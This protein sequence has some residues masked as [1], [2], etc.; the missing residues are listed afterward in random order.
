MKGIQT[1][2]VKTDITFSDEAIPVIITLHEAINAHDM[3]ATLAF[4]ADDAVAN[5]PGQ[6]PP[7]VLNGKEQIRTGWL[8]DDFANN[9]H[10]EIGNIQVTDDQLIWMVTISWDFLRPLGI[11]SLEGM[12]KAIVQGGMIKSF[13]A[14]F[15]PGSLAKIEAGITKE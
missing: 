14:I 11:A 13:T 15:P 6:P 4:F 1:M 10:V 7:N 8:E 3:D 9:V 2:K 12:G 5:F